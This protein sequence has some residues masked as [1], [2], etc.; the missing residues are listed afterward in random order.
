MSP[1][2]SHELWVMP[3]TDTSSGLLAKLASA[4]ALFG[5]RRYQDTG[6]AR[7]LN[8]IQFGRPKHLGCWAVIGL[9]HLALTPCLRAGARKAEPKAAWAF[10]VDPVPSNARGLS[11][12]VKRARTK[13]NACF[14]CNQPGHRRGDPARP[15]FHPGGGQS[16]RG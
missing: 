16:L 10:L 7:P 12:A 6:K 11:A 8:L 13:A 15:G 2:A 14:A 9:A 5:L 1:L 4:L 3:S